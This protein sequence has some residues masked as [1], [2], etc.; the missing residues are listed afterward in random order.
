MGM[1]LWGDF[2]GGR[3]MENCMRDVMMHQTGNV[4]ARGGAAAAAWSAIEALEGRTLMAATPPAVT[5]LTL[6]NAQTDKAIGAFTNGM[7]IDL[8]KVGRS[9]SVRADATGAT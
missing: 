6:I 3:P 7:T 9:L 8:N 5:G 4:R 2:Q 1:C